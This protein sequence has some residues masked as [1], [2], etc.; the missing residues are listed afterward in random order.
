MY[1][2]RNIG[3][4]RSY[5]YLRCL[6]NALLFGH[7]VSHS[8]NSQT[9]PFSRAVM[10]Q[11]CQPSCSFPKGSVTTCRLNRQTIYC[12]MFLFIKKS[13]RKHEG[14]ENM[15]PVFGQR[16]ENAVGPLST[17]AFRTEDKALSLGRAQQGFHQKCCDCAKIKLCLI[18][19]L[20]FVLSTNSVSATFFIQPS[21]HLA[22][23]NN[24][25][26]NIQI[27]SASSHPTKHTQMLSK[28]D[29]I[30]DIF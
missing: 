28:R 24:S 26:K 25:R 15:K 21:P 13:A 11:K 5:C 14:K 18:L 6:R 7:Y 23:N 17:P 8:P 27:S 22:A 2:Q 12:V 10:R 1:R 29:F 20:S 3:Q 30:S 4:L 19:E 16:G 9:N